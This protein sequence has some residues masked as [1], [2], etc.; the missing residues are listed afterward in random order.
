[1]K[2]MRPVD[3][4]FR[5]LPRGTSITTST[6]GGSRKAA[7]TVAVPF[8]GIRGRDILPGEGGT[9]AAIISAMWLTK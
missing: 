9:V 3:P 6:S 4:R 2:S 8:A 5:K 7:L 1:M